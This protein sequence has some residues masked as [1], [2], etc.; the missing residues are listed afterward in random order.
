M[1]STVKRMDDCEYFKKVNIALLKEYIAGT[2]LFLETSILLHKELLKQWMTV[3]SSVKI[4]RM[5]VCQRMADYH[6][7][8]GK[9]KC[10]QGRIQGVLE[11]GK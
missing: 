1:Y 7:F 4:N 11:A 9:N 10:P 5:V 6:Y 8:C 3:S 2:N